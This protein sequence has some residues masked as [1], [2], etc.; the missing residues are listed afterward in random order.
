MAAEY[1]G[2]LVGDGEDRVET[3]RKCEVDVL[4]DLIGREVVLAGLDLHQCGPGAITSGDPNQP[5]RAELLL[6]QLE[7]NF[8]V[9]G[10]AARRSAAG[11]GDQTAELFHRAHDG[12]K[13]GSGSTFLLSRA[14]YA[15]YGNKSGLMP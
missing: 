1:G 8:D 9:G 10:E 15:R 12:Q 13:G 5:V 7:G 3:V 6:S 14:S 11:I 4:V 2:E